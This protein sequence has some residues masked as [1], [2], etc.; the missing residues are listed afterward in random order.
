[1]QTLFLSMGVLV[2]PSVIVFYMIFLYTIVVLVDTHRMSLRLNIC[3]YRNKTLKEHEFDMKIQG[4]YANSFFCLQRVVK[5]VED[6][7]KMERGKQILSTIAGLP[8]GNIMQV[9]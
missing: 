7:D 1:M 9:I 5:R 2:T 8:N 6:A 4:G 3:K